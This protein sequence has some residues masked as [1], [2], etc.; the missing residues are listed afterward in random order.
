MTE[1]FPQT[2][3][4]HELDQQPNPETF[5]VER[6]IRSP[7]GE[8]TG[9]HI[10]SGWSIVDTENDKDG[11]QFVTLSRTEEDGRV[12]GKTF[13]V[14]KFNKIQA[15]KAKE[16]GAQIVR[17]EYETPEAADINV[18]GVDRLLGDYVKPE[19]FGVSETVTVDYLE[20]VAS[21]IE[22]GDAGDS[23]EYLIKGSVD[24]A[25]IDHDEVAR[26]GI[27]IL[28]S[29]R[30]VAEFIKKDPDAAKILIKRGIVGFHGTESSAFASMLKEG[31]LLS[32][33]EVRRRGIAHTTGE[34]F[35]QKKEGQN[36][37]SFTT[38]AD[39]NHALDYAG[40]L[41]RVKKSSGDVRKEIVDQIS[42]DRTRLKENPR[43]NER[44]KGVIAIGIQEDE[45]T[46]R[47][48]DASPNSLQ[49]ELMRD[50]FPML[51][52]INTETVFAD[53]EGREN[54]NILRAS[55][56]YNEFRPATESIDLNDT[57]IAVPEAHVAQVQKLLKRFG[58]NGASVISLNG[59]IS[60]KESKRAS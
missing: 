39:L 17:S 60:D 24:G 31:S 20:H 19:R 38:L 50:S 49:M 25:G 58:K 18:S 12:L 56:D 9:T 59:F 33:A 41:D 26:N 8:I 14:E 32:A 28:G 47:E 29:R 13:S 3:S 42:K 37:I 55:S 44:M 57:V 16:L 35:W 23:V 34:H 15:V 2:P 48:F 52:G 1:Q 30:T 5:Y 54:W 7:E 40:S 10:E 46:L 27:D 45:Q 51:F 11:N 6:N 43:L 21:K 53:V 4:Q 22:S 36:S